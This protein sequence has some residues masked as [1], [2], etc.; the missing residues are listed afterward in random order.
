LENC[1]FG[2]LLKANNNITF[3]ILN[4]PAILAH[5]VQMHVSVFSVIFSD[6]CSV[7]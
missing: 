2:L 6:F 7:L 5:N 3:L 1:I 4:S